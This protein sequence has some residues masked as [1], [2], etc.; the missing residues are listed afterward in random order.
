M[1]RP[2]L[3]EAGLLASGRPGRPLGWLAEE[4]KGWKHEKL[5]VDTV[6]AEHGQSGTTNLVDLSVSFFGY[7]L[8]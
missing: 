8:L 7:D 1:A 2:S 3:R 4:R 5:S 6:R